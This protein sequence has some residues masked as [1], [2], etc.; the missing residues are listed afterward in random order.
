M[1]RDALIVGISTYEFLPS[2]GAPGYDAEAIAQRLQTS[3]DFRVTRM[4]EIVQSGQTKVGVKT[5]VTLAELEAAL[6]RLFKPKGSNIPHTALFYYSG[7]GLQKEAGIQ[8]GYLATS[9]ANPAAGRYGLSL[10]WLRRLLQESPVRQRIVLLDCCN[11]GELLNFVEADPGAKAGTDRL[12]MAAAREYESAYESISG[13]YSVFTQAL[14]DGLDPDRIANGIVTNYALTDW[15][16]NA[17]K[18]ETQQPLF[19][20]SGSE[21]TLTRGQSVTT[22]LKTELSTAICPYRGLEY[23]DE[24]H[25]SYFFGR[26]DLTD[27]LV[28]KLKINHFVAVLGAS[29]S[30]KSSLIR[31]GLIHKLRQQQKFAGCDRWR[32][33]L[34][35]P[36]DQPLKSLATAF[37]NP[38]ASAIDRADQLRRAEIFLHEGGSGLAQ[39]ARASLISQA[40]AKPRLL[41]VIDQFEE[42][43]TLCQGPHA[44]RDRLRFFRCLMDALV[45]ASDCLSLVIGLRADFFGK[46]SL[47]NG[48]A[49]QIERNLLTVMPLTYDQIK[50]SVTKPAQKVGLGY[51]PNLVYNILL[52]VVGAPGEL[53]LLQYTLLELWHRR[54]PNSAGG[55]DRLTLDAYTALGGVRGTL[56]K[57]ADEIFYSLSPIEQRVARRIFIALTQLGDGTEDTRRRILK[58]ELVSPQYPIALVNQVLEKLVRAKLVVTSQVAAPICHQDR[59]DQSIASMSTALRLTQIRRGKSPKV[60]LL[61][62]SPTACPGSPVIE[63]LQTPKIARITRLPVSQLAELTT[64]EPRTTRCQE[65]VDVAHEALIRNWSLLRTWL[66]ENRERLQRQRWIEQA[67]REWH[68]IEQP[69]STAYLLQGDRLLDAMDY[70]NGHPE[71]LSTLAQ[72]YITMSQAERQ[73]QQTKL[74]RLQ[75]AVPCT[76]LVALGSTFNQYRAAV[77]NQTEK[78]AQARVALSRQRAA[79]A[80]SI[81]RDPAGDPTAALLISRLAAEQG[82][83]TY[84]AQASLRAALQK[85]RLQA[86]FTGHRGAVQQIVFSPNQRQFATAGADGTVRIWSLQQQQVEQVLHWQNDAA[87]RSPSAH[88]RVTSLAFSPDGKQ[89]A[90]T[91]ENATSIQVWSVASGAMQFK[92]SGLR[93]PIGQFAFSPTGA[94]IAAVS[95]DQT[96]RLWRTTTGDIQ[97]QRTQPQ[98]ITAL[99]FSSD[100]QWLLIAT[101]QT[102]ELLRA[103]T[104]KTEQK[105]LHPCGVTS[106]RFSPDG[107][108]IATGC[109][110]G[111]TWLRSL[112]GGR[113]RHRLSPRA[114]QGSAK[115]SGTAAR[116]QVMFSPDSQRLAIVDQ[117]QI[118]VWHVQNGRLQSQFPIAQTPDPSHPRLMAFSQDSQ[119]LITTQPMV[120]GAAPSAD[121]L[122]LWDIQT[123]KI[124]ERFEAHTE[125]ITAM[126]LSP[127][128]SLIAT[129][130]VNGSVRLWAT[131]A[132]GEFPVLQVAGTAIYAANFRQSVVA[133]PE[134]ERLSQSRHTPNGLNPPPLSAASTRSLNRSTRPVPTPSLRHGADE[135]VTIQPNGLMQRLRWLKPR[136]LPAAVSQSLHQAQN[137]QPS[138]RS[139]AEARSPLAQLEAA[140]ASA[141]SRWQQFKSPQMKPAPNQFPEPLSQLPPQPLTEPAATTLNLA[142]KLAPGLMLTSAAF[143]PNRQQVATAD[144]SGAIELWQIQPQFQVKPLRRLQPVADQSNRAGAAVVIRHLSFSQDGKKLLG[145][146]RDQRIRIWDLDG[147]TMH[148][149]PAQAK[150]IQSA[151]FSPDGQQLVSVSQDK[152]AHIWQANNGQLVT[153]LRQETAI[154]SIHFSPNNM[155]VVTTSLDRITRVTD[156]QSGKLRVA[157]TGHQGAVLDAEFSPNGQM[158]VTAS[159][160]GT[161]RLWDAKT[162]TERAILRPFDATEPAEPI[163]QAFFSPDGHFVATLSQSGK[164]RLWV[165]TWEGLLQ[166]AHDR[167]LRQL[168]PEECLRYLGLPPSACPVLAHL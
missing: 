16:S 148:Q 32:I 126:Q 160:D 142:E 73:R 28:E 51:E 13:N 5:P 47:Y 136:A 108:T 25:A 68:Q 165:A 113:L 156:I 130:S 99:A 111:S 62:T 20:N 27:Q 125:P 100:G 41:L 40:D 71:D 24:I 166:V 8:E 74:R 83:S 106:A 139:N 115:N 2:L 29:G 119:R 82:G 11:S 53:P 150:P 78:D 75:F 33:H 102:A 6:V 101:G 158:I 122:L 129:A 67:A 161:A 140:V 46:C 19:E 3:G 18:G 43:F 89:L 153:T 31:A 12:F 69:R 30:G 154:H 120:A 103:D 79:I 135:V 118:Q 157:L 128:G 65:T 93:Q 42:V 168:K 133:G 39:L 85:L 159:S 109:T 114:S 57:R 163:Q 149:L 146:G 1:S 15:M 112:S 155:L 36:T 138:T 92:L 151:Y 147:G 162:G 22:V 121:S 164:L 21:I 81:L 105:L 37:V 9:E 116:P 52:D 96:L 132:D 167:S 91:A 80:Q 77:Q 34:I 143:N 152:I 98:S 117:A 35:T 137:Q 97:L 123:G 55:G 45:E 66:D 54:Q 61:P 23:F 110:D 64:S 134:G 38:S 94:T 4:P 58:S 104:G 60:L 48:L 88:P 107:Q 26:E 50:A 10:F 14:I 131:T 87:S 124:I 76:L 72:R 49:D 145:I 70:L 127:D 63:A 59:V 44:E 7:H 86:Q 144:S 17:L 90:A 56:Q 84:E 141:R 95:A